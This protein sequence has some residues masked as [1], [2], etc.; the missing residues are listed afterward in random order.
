[1]PNANPPRD[2]I[3]DGCTDKTPPFSTRKSALTQSKLPFKP[4]SK[5]SRSSD[6]RATVPLNNKKPRQVEKTDGNQNVN[7]DAEEPAS[8]KEEEEIDYSSE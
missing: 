3:G 2:E 6:S 4:V 7:M 8:N 5:R 1:M